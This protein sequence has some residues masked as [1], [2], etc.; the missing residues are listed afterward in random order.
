MKVRR[1]CGMLRQQ[2]LHVTLYGP[3]RSDAD[4]DEHVVIT[5]RK[6][7]KRWGFGERFNT[8]TSPFSWDANETYWQQ[9]NASAAAH[10]MQRAGR[11]DILCLTTSAQLAVADLN[12]HLTVAEWAVGYEGIH[13][14]DRWFCAFESHAWRHHVYG[15]RGWRT[16]RP[17]DTVIPN[18]FDPHDFH[19]AP[20]GD[21]LLFVGRVIERKGPHVAAEIAKRAGMRLIIAGP[22]GTHVSEGVVHTCDTGLR[23]EGNLSYVG[24]VNAAD[25]AELMAGARALVV[26]TLY[27]EPFGGVAVEAMLSGTPVVASDWGA[28]V[29]TVTPDVGARFSTLAQ[30]EAALEHALTLDPQQI[31]ARAVERFS[32]EAVGPRFA[33]WFRQ[34]DTLWEAGWY[35][36]RADRERDG[37]GSG[38]PRGEPAAAAHLP[39]P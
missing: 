23:V 11:R 2:G 8:A 18:F 17:F 33:D 39:A 31:R 30:A 14:R 20:K 21:Y 15:L 26:P 7:R 24:E 5:T 13:D 12:P 1:F 3:D 6:D 25:R 16:G 32:V 29:E 27:L 28:F 4:C 35:Q 19:R 9:A 38:Q 10:V 22:G 37:Q 34:L 36:P